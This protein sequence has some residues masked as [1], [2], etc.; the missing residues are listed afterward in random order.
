M[1]SRQ[2]AL[3]ISEPVGK[4]TTMIDNDYLTLKKLFFFDQ[5]N[6]LYLN[7]VVSYFSRI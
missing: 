4:T 5:L 2:S 3:Q 1:K 7:N 6:D